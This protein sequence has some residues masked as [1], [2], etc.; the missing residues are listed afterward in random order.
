MGDLNF[1]NKNAHE[2]YAFEDAIQLKAKITISAFLA[3]YVGKN[4]I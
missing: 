4:K 2:T 3:F 1:C